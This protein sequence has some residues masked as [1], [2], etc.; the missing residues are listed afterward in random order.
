MKNVVLAS[1][2]RRHLF[3]KPIY[4]SESSDDTVTESIATHASFRLVIGPLS[5]MSISYWWKQQARQAIL[6]ASTWQRTYICTLSVK[7]QKRIIKVN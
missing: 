7:V 5:Q 1:Q 6:P 3:E 2:T 4:K